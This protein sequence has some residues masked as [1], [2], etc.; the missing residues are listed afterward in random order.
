M[1]LSAEIFVYTLSTMEKWGT[2]TIRQPKEDPLAYKG[3]EGS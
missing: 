3:F 2:Y 1:D